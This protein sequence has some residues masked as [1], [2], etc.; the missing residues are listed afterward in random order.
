[1]KEPGPSIDA[2]PVLYVIGGLCLKILAGAAIAGCA[3]LLACV[4]LGV[5]P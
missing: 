2:A 3:V 1:M 5:M 4:A